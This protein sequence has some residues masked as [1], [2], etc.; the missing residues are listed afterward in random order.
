[1][2]SV[3]DFK[4]IFSLGFRNGEKKPF[5]KDEEIDLLKLFYDFMISANFSKDRQDL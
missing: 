5:I 1:M 3:D 2:P 4:D